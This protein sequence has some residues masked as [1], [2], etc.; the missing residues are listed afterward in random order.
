MLAPSGIPSTISWNCSWSSM[1]GPPTYIRVNAS[2]L[3]MFALVDGTVN[4]LP[5][6]VG[7]NPLVAKFPFGPS[8][9]AEVGK[10]SPA[11]SFSIHIV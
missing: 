9:N 7:S 1:I 2:T 5:S 10:N 11:A 3:V 4:W 8:S 6:T